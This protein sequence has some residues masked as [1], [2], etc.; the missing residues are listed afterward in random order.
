MPR[1]FVLT[2]CYRFDEYAPVNAKLYEFFREHGFKNPNSQLINPY[3]FAHRTGNQD[4]W[5]YIDSFPD[6]LKNLNLGMM[7]QTGATAWTVGIF[8]FQDEL[9]KLNTNEETVLVIDIGG[10][11]GHVSKKIRDLTA[12]I[13][14]KIILQERPEALNDLVDSLP[15]IT[16]MEY[17]FFTP[18]PIK[19]M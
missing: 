11:K 5:E 18:Q 15:G 12:G 16:T 4:M 10:G 3:C 17:D 1:Y 14:G 9:S 8:P 2:S 6:R 13:S 7:A 19:G